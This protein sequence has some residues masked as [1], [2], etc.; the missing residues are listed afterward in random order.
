MVLVTAA[1]FYT[2]MVNV[3][4]DGQLH[5]RVVGGPIAAPMRAEFMETFLDG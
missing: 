5:E 1:H 3:A 4:I 2:A